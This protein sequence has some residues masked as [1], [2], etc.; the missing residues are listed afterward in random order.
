[1]R[2]CLS[3][4]APL[5]CLA[6]AAGVHGQAVPARVDDLDFQLYNGCRPVNYLVE[7]TGD[8]VA[9]DLAITHKQIR[10]L[11]EVRLRS[12]R[13]YSAQATPEPF[14]YVRIN[15][16][17]P[18]LTSFHPVF[19]IEVSFKKVVE[20]LITG[21]RSAAETWRTGT[22]GRAPAD[23]IRIAVSDDLDAFI[24]EYLRANERACDPTPK[25][26]P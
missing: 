19:R 4:A 16:L 10:D 2:L 1:M 8:E 25:Q 5:L 22:F 23:R 14:L 26:V 7:K 3:C 18:P 11:V 21:Q 13:L 9:E 6:V 17:E 15:V 24:L 20:D 12:A